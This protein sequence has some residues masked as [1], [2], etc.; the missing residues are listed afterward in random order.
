MNRPLS[1]VLSSEHLKH[2][3][4]WCDDLIRIYREESAPEA[5]V[6]DVVNKADRNERLGKYAK[7]VDALNDVGVSKGSKTENSTFTKQDRGNKYR[8]AK[9]LRRSKPYSCPVNEEKAK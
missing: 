9:L 1:A 5:T 2:S 6:G 7:S 3:S 4:S 8:I